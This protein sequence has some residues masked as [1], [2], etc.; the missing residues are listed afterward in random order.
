M[1]GFEQ[2]DV[3]SWLDDGMTIHVESKTHHRPR[4]GA[5][6]FKRSIGRTGIAVS[7]LTVATLVVPLTEP[8]S[9]AQTQTE[10]S[11]SSKLH[12]N[13]VQGSIEQPEAYWLAIRNAM[14]SWKPTDESGIELPPDFL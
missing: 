9:T 4:K 6:G 14:A 8:F 7:L 3:D 10:V 2:F 12:S 5:K 11:W 1:Q 13:A